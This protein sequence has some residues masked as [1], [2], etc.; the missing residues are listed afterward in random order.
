[1]ISPPTLPHPKPSIDTRS[2]VRPNS[3]YSMAVLLSSFI[4]NAINDV[5]TIIGNEYR[6]IRHHLYIDRPSP[7]T[8]IAQPAL[9][10]GFI[11]YRPMVVKTH[12]R[13][14]IADGRGAVPGA[15]FGDEN[16]LAIRFREH[17]ARIKAHAERRDVG[18]EVLRR[19]GELRARALA[20]ELGVGNAPAVAIGK[21]KV[22]PGLRGTI[23][24]IR[25][26][27]VA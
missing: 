22:H 1:M 14:A 8:S 27:I 20:A 9:G 6:P 21:P 17:R 3:R 15:M 25:R 18:T 4:D 5:G 13:Q 24:L 10:K 12:Q 16:L 19:R 11:R 7:G 23:Q 26:A 2:P